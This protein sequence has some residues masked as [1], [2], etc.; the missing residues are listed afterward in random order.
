MSNDGV[1]FIGLIADTH[2]L[3]RPDVRAALAGVE[4]IL[5][6]G[7]VGGDAILDELQLIAPV[8]A[9]YGNTDVPGE[10]RLT[11]AIDMEVGGVRIHVS[12]GHELGSPTPEKLLE[13]YDADVIVYGHT[14]KQLV[15]NVDGR[16]VVN[17]GAAGPRRFNLLPSV[18]RLTIANGQPEIRIVDLGG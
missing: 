11:T 16:W 18:G 6:A 12:H 17:P 13:R 5:H 9:V 10:P 15:T 1:H 2:G 7:D 4:L 14:H 3:V 8:Q